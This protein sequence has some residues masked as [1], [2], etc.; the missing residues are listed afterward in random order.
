[1]YRIFHS[2]AVEYLFSQMH[3]E[4]FPGYIIYWVIKQLPINVKR[5]KWCKIFPDLLLCIPFFLWSQIEPTANTINSNLYLL[6]STWPQG[7]AW[8]L[9]PWAV[10]RNVLAPSRKIGS[11]NSILI[12]FPLLRHDS[13][14]LPLYKWKTILNTVF[15]SF[16]YFFMVN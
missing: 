1:M 8:V 10:V 16:S 13:L 6:N 3:I 14:V 11:D 2:T 7:S 9:T 15:C 4:H 12:S 5:L